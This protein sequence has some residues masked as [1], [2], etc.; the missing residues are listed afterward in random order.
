MS[1][2]G[3]VNVFKDVALEHAGTAITLPAVPRP[4]TP[5]EGIDALYEI[6]SALETD[7]ALHHEIECFPLDGAV[8]FSRAM[9]QR[10]GHPIGTKT[11]P[12]SMF[13]SA[14]P[15]VLISVAVSPTEKIQVPW[16]SVK[17]PGISGRFETKT[18]GNPA[19]GPKFII[20]GEIKKKHEKEAQEI[21]SLTEKLLRSNSIYKG[22]AIRVS[23]SWIREERPFD[24]NLDSPTFIDTT[25]SDRDSLILPKK[26]MDLIEQGLFMPIENAERCRKHG[27]PLKR[28][29][30]LTG[31]F[32]CGKTLTASVTAKIC[33]K[34]NWTFLYLKDVNDLAM[35]MRY[36]KLYSPCVIFAEDIDQATDKGR[37]TELNEILN[38]IDGVDY[39]Q[40]EII[41][42][43]TTNEPQKINKAMIRPGRLDSVVPV[44][45]P[46][47]D[48]AE[49]LI[50]LYARDL[51]HPETDI[52]TAAMELKGN[53]PSTIREAVERSKLIALS[54]HEDITG[55]VTSE[56]L[57][58]ALEGM[59]PH[60]ELMEGAVGD[61][62]SAL[63]VGL[64]ALGA[65]AGMAIAANAPGLSKL[66][67]PPPAIM[68]LIGD[69]A[70]AKLAGLGSGPPT[71]L[72]DSG[73]PK[74]VMEAL[75]SHIADII[76]KMEE[77]SKN[78]SIKDKDDGKDDENKSSTDGVG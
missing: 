28:G 78:A 11:P 72:G 55:K 34:N 13:D 14:T 68:A 26:T 1:S 16:G 46:D 6:E 7:V 49:R 51:L 66:M 10:Y 3:K 57:K 15:P 65:G 23:F 19:S 4:M 71:Q 56:D 60:L 64:R 22:R 9:L 70:A 76:G 5:K 48:A 52:A 43:V 27:I 17:V 38:T 42:I 18:P 20:G 74:E 58:A 63:E 53:I 44:E 73:L 21:S 36:A 29:V 33:E 59:K 24:P 45:L 8:A 61:G 77:G 35:A 50:R 2:D 47:Q 41:T 62:P 67:L 54:R 75:A 39:K 69:G 40:E 12:K 25:G 32:G 30:L 37:N 31:Q